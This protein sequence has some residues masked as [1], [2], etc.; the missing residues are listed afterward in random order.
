VT[1]GTSRL[2]DD[3]FQRLKQ[4]AASSGLSLNKLMEGVGTAAVAAHAAKADRGAGLDVLDRLD[5]QD[6]S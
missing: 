6:R 4:P 1:T 3:I 2:P 5:Q